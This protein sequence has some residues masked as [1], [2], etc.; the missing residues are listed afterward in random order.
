MTLIEAQEKYPVGSKWDLYGRTVE[1]QLVSRS[2]TPPRRVHVARVYVGDVG[3]KLFHPQIPINGAEEM[4]S[5][6]ESKQAKRQV[7]KN[8]RF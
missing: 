5:G 6:N 3:R 4:A 1:V 8:F 2:G 7:V